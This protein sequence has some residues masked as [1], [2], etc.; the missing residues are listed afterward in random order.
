VR[1]AGREGLPTGGRVALADS[2]GVPGATSDGP[3]GPDSADLAVIPAALRRAA[4]ALGMS[5]EAVVP[6]GGA[7]R[8]T[9]G[10]GEHV[11]RIGWP[12][13]LDREVLAMG[14]ASSVL[15]VPRVL[16]R[17]EFID[18]RGHKRAALLLTRLP[19]R[20]AGDLTGVSPQQARR[21]GEACGALHAVLASVVPPP[22]LSRELGPPLLREEHAK[23]A[24][25]R[26]CLLHLDLHPLN[27][28]IDRGGEVSGVLDWANTAAGAAV[29][30]RARTWSILTLDP[31]ALAL[32]DLPGWTALTSGWARTAGFDDLPAA[33]R[34]WACRVMLDDLAGRYRADALEHVR[35]SLRVH[36]R[37]SS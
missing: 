27:V 31:S 12:D 23:T 17:V 20:P 19:G 1:R 13:V 15:A 26:P 7:S 29:L 9:W 16:D 2:P 10:C 25:R 4:A 8:R 30:D 21:R 32:H 36:D 11:L 28:L 3:D 34:A 33:A 22:G 6:L 18:E 14:A 5:E 37:A 35:R 24:Q